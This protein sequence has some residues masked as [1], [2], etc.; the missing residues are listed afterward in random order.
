MN[1]ET[2]KTKSKGTKN[3]TKTILN[4]NKN[5][6]KKF[7]NKEKLSKEE[8]NINFEDITDTVDITKC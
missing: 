1:K 2:N 8:T 7:F 4:E 3:E 6:V 5:E